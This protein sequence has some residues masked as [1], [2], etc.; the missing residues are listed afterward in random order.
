MT[1]NAQEEVKSAAPQEQSLSNKEL[2]FRKQEQ[3]YQ[4]ML[5]EKEAE[6]QKLL[7]SRSS[8]EEDDYSEP[9]VDH[10]KLD[11]KLKSFEQTNI[12]TIKSE[13]KREVMQALE[14]EKK[15]NWMRANQDFADVLQHAEKLYQQD[16]EFAETLL[17]A[18][19]KDREFDRQKAVYLAIKSKGLHKPQTQEPSIQDKINANRRS[20]YYQPSGM[21][22]APYQSQ[23][24]FSPEGQK[25]AYEK[26]QELK[27]N[28]RL[29]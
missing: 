10:R 16:P 29:G 21:S 20:P 2:N 27:R 19:P 26:M 13:A 6:I 1:I 15:Q 28:L 11:K 22:S 9:Y 3:M 18:I 8:Q 25:R 12:E 7:Q 24:D 5:Q 23:G 17:N 4:K 14:E